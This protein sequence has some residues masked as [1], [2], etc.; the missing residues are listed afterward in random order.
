MDAANYEPAFV[1]SLFDEMAQTYGIVNLIS[2]FGFAAR[3]RKQ[4]IRRIAIRPG[5]TVV[6]LMTGMAEL[7]PDLASRVGGSGAI[8]AIDLSPEMCRRARQQVHRCRCPVEIIEGDVLRSDLGTASADIVVSSFGLKTFSARQMGHLAEQIV[9]ILKPGGRFS[10]LE[11]SVPP[12]RWLRWPYMFY[13]RRV[14][15]FIGRAF[16]G[17]PENYRMLG[18]YTE[19]FGNCATMKEE[20][21]RVGL[22]AEEKSYFFGCATGVFGHRPA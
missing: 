20:C 18:V 8:Q 1:R 9:R 12:N 13:V 2:S 17:N 4:C 5:S 11:I 16:L 7:C 10:L 6:D 14:I 15:P 22:V 19:A 3:W 21:A